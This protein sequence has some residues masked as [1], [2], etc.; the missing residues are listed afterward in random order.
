M[1]HFVKT[2]A[3]YQQALEETKKFPDFMLTYF[4]I[5]NFVLKRFLEFELKVFSY[6]LPSGGKLWIIARFNV[7]NRPYMIFGIDQNDKIDYENFKNAYDEV[8]THMPNL[9]DNIPKAFLFV[10]VEQLFELYYKYMAEKFPNI[11][12]VKEECNFFYSNEEQIEYLKNLHIELPEGYKFDKVDMEK[13]L[14]TISDSWQYGVL[15]EKERTRAKLARLPYS[16]IREKSSGKPIAYELVDPSGYINHQYT[17]P[18]HRQKGLGNAVEM[19]VSR[20]CIDGYINHQYTC[21]EHRQKGLGNAVEMDV[22]RKCIE[23]GI[24]PN[25]TVSIKN[26]N[27]ESSKRCPY[28]TLWEHNGNPVIFAYGIHEQRC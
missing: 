19:D 1:L 7:A 13:D 8:L 21:P 12:I 20:K 27:F 9:Y 23:I 28:W 17:C 2:E 16:L 15:G 14:D 25:K 11:K 26:T 6:K 18:E 22:S 10:G 3:E 5:E 4:T 24:V